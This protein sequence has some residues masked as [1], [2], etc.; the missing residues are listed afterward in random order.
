[1][2]KQTNHSFVIPLEFLPQ[3]LS[4]LNEN[5]YQIDKDQSD[6]SLGFF[7]LNIPQNEIPSI[8][9]F[10]QEIKQL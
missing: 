7:A 1:M 6:L 8:I 5:D 10:V 4:F 9:D 2:N 3:T